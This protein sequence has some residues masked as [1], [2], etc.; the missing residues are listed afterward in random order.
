[1]TSV[2]SFVNW[3]RMGNFLFQ[4]AAAIG[5]AVQCRLEFTVPAQRI[6]PSYP[7]Y[8]PHLVNPNY[9]S[10]LPRIVVKEKVFHH[11]KILFDEA[12]R[13]GHN[14]VLEGYWQS[15]KYF[16]DIRKN[17]IASFG[18]PWV[19]QEG[20][21]SVHVRRGDYLRWTKKHPKVTEEWINAAMERFKGYQFL[22]FS[23]DLDWCKKT[24]GHR[25]DCSFSL[26]KNEVDDLICMSQCEHH[27]CS[28]STFSWW[29]AWL[30]RNPAKQVIIPKLWFVPGWGGHNDSDV[31][32]VEWDRL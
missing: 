2:V 17:I 28:A 7:V 3:G 19:P 20:V 5:Y 25:K 16:K 6:H 32:P 29:A 15:E 26:G 13:E 18:F 4:A 14:I 24:F 12:W 10:S 22:F 27:V 23:D 9:D 8:L 31:V 30:N 1:M 21:V 11:H